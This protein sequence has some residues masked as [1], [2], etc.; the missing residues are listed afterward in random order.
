MY[1]RSAYITIIS[2]SHELLTTIDSW[3]DQLLQ[4]TDTIKNLANTSK[5]NDS[6]LTSIDLIPVKYKP[7]SVEFTISP[8]Y[9]ICSKFSSAA[10]K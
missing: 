5:L 4:N 8:S 1:E 3:S 7:H 9:F 2:K 6:Y 10:L